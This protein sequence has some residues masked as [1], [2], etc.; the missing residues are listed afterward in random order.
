MSSAPSVVDYM[1][2]VSALELRP[3]KLFRQAV[4][5]GEAPNDLFATVY[6]MEFV[7]SSFGK[8]LTKARKKAIPEPLPR[9]KGHVTPWR[10][11]TATAAAATEGSGAEP[12]VEEVKESEAK[13]AM[14]AKLEH[15]V[16]LGLC[17]PGDG[18]TSVP[19][20]QLPG[21]IGLSELGHLEYHLP[22]LGDA[23]K[24]SNAAAFEQLKEEWRGAFEPMVPREGVAL[25]TTIVVWSYKAAS[26]EGQQVYFRV[27]WLVNGMMVGVSPWCATPRSARLHA[28]VSFPSETPTSAAYPRRLVHQQLFASSASPPM[29]SAHDD[30]SN[31]V[32]LSHFAADDVVL[33]AARV[34]L[35]VAAVSRIDPIDCASLP[36]PSARIVVEGLDQE[37]FCSTTA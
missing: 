21:S 29:D 22:V 17:L 11:P 3:P 32:C 36:D 10:P 14:P 35:A 28:A 4:R 12:K 18:N 37:P 16:W 2:A 6:E 26:M 1:S 13:P 25:V 5:Q 33:P 34:A 31:I 27:V 20:G 23:A 9:R 8:G 7:R 19:V 15:G 30:T 24:S